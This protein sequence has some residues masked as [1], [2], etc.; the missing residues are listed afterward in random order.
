MIQPC[1]EPL[2]NRRLLTYLVLDFIGGPTWAP[3]SGT[4]YV[5][6]GHAGDRYW[7]EDEV[8]VV[9]P[10]SGFLPGHASGDSTSFTLTNLPEHTELQIAVNPQGRLSTPVLVGEPPPEGYWRYEVDFGSYSYWWNSDGSASEG[11]PLSFIH[12]EDSIDVTLT[13]T[14]HGDPDPNPTW[15]LDRAIVRRRTPIIDISPHAAQNVTI[16]AQEHIDPLPN[17]QQLGAG[18]VAGWELHRRDDNRLTDLFLDVDWNSFSDAAV[19]DTDYELRLFHGNVDKGVI[20]GQ[21]RFEAQRE[22]INIVLV[23]KDDGKIEADEGVYPMLKERDGGGYWVD[24]LPNPAVDGEVQIKDNEVFI[25]LLA[26][27]N[28]TKAGV[29]RMRGDLLEGGAFSSEE[30][31]Q[32]NSESAL[33]TGGHEAWVSRITH[34]SSRFS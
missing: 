7:V 32:T 30:V 31:W 19:K 3:P 27:F 4:E 1:I 22:R 12:F 24:N 6:T 21:V 20:D 5:G 25:T 14:W 9:A 13:G 28:D 16:H 33:G 11:D 29:V 8:N 10:R 34:L 15:V 17:A 26:G 2:E 18:V 23:P